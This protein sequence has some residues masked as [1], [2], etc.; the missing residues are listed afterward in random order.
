MNRL[1]EISRTIVSARPKTSHNK[2]LPFAFAGESFR[3]DKLN[4]E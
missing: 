3:E 4:M 2:M 1:V